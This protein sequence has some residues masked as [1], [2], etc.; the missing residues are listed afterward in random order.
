M[1][2]IIPSSGVD[3]IVQPV[4]VTGANNLQGRGSYKPKTRGLSVQAFSFENTRRNK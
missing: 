2:V 3:T 1:Q 4:Q